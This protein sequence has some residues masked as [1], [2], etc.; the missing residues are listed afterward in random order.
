MHFVTN[1]AMLASCSDKC[2][3]LS[4]RLHG[5]LRSTVCVC[6]ALSV[7]VGN[8]N[9]IESHA[10]DYIWEVHGQ[11]ITKEYVNL[12][13]KLPSEAFNTKSNFK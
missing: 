7:F 1:E 10:K 11:T 8:G 12:N 6:L 9:G 2:V 3:R 13:L 5:K 4:S